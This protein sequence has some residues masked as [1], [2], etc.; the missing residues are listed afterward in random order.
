MTEPPAGL[1]TALADRY[2]LDR[3]LGRGGMATVWLA[4]DVRHGRQVAVKVLHP[5][6]GAV[7]G[8][9]RFLAE[10]RTTA[11][12]SHPGI[13]PLFDSGTAAGQVFYVMPYV[14]GESLRARMDREGQ[15]PV[16][17]A[18]R[19]TVEVA[20]ALAHAHG[21]GVIHR[22][23][24]PENI[25]LQGGHP[26]LA[27]FGIALAVQEAGGGRLT[28][29]GLSLGTP[30]YMSPEQAGAERSVDGRSDIYS[31]GAVL[32]EMLAGV[33]PFSAPTTQAVL[34]KLMTE[35][36]RPLVA[37][38]K[39]VPDHVADAV[40]TALEKLPADRFATPTEFAQALGGGT[41]PTRR[42]ADA[43]T[44][45]RSG[46]RA[47]ALAAGAA[48]LV[49]GGIAGVLAARA[50]AGPPASPPP[51]HLAIL[52]ENVGGSGGPALR[53]QLAFTP[54]AESVVFVAVDANGVNELRRQR[55][56]AP[57]PVRV[58]GS[59]SLAGPVISPDG[60]WVF[61][62]GS[63]GTFRLPLAGG[64]RTRLPEDFYLAD[65]APD[66]T[67]WFSTAGTSVLKRL[68]PGMDTAEVAVGGERRFDVHQV[69][70]ARTAIV[71]H[72]VV[73][74]SSG[75]V[76]LLDLVRGDTTRLLDFV[77]VEARYTA[78]H[79]VW[80][81]P[82]GNLGASTWDR[83][84][85][86]R[87]P[88]VQLTTGVSLTGT[89]IAQVAVAPNG[90]VAYIPESP[91]QLAHVD[92]QGAA[93]PLL[94]EARTFHAPQ[95]SPD[96]SRLAFDFTSAEGRDSWVLD[97]VQGTLIRATF[98]GDGHDATW[99]PD[100]RHLT[101][102]SARSGALGIY[103][104]RPGTTGVAESRVATPQLSWTGEWAAD[105]SGLVT[106]A[107]LTPGSES[108]VAFLAGGG[109]GPLEPLVATP[110]Y[111]AYPAL[112]PDGRWLAYVSN[113]SGPQQV[114]V[115]PFPG[116]EGD[117]S[118][119]VSL[120]GGSEPVWSPDGRRLAYRGTVEGRP[121][122][123]LVDVDGSGPLRIRGR[124]ALFSL[125]DFIA[126]APHANYDFA[127]DGEGFVMVRRSPSSRIMVIQNLPALVRRL[128]GT[129]GR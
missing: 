123:V 72:R 39:S 11:H 119:Q 67:F 20:E 92:F 49:L 34:V 86:R 22:D 126:T 41:A 28:Q 120:D 104:I 9:E 33:P 7:L 122:L 75:L 77:V 38:R 59:S 52:A 128:E 105:G 6:L 116:N 95:Y 25:L 27:D 55:L 99:A 89:G 30:Q 24:K 23:I 18:V 2:R 64:P 129:A 68:R 10:I 21:Q 96:G 66:G 29:T 87:G 82:D 5:E 93:R 4:H 114:Y 19:I 12:L 61:A 43:P 79:L 88:P 46:A 45:R 13:L 127:P 56:D 102:V 109:R 90:S 57:E 36:P 32:Y 8:V 40:H 50:L 118:V 85:E 44:R 74:T 111:E 125:A 110:F 16:G 76:Y 103:R 113:R 1:T 65:V 71:L 35:E 70:D 100:G 80:V 37:L 84:R 69:L 63:E 62:S 81:T 98:A 124:R 47:V 42:R 48:G 94:A 51:S 53:R 54:D 3:E 31:L 15:L 83:A 112:S 106:T 58:E 14:P 73:G 78:G 115:R 60:R 101:Y 107:T 26:L 17:D 108:D 117:E 97:L 121:E 91:R